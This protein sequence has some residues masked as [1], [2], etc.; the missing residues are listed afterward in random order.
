VGAT[1]IA[2][3]ALEAE[4]LAKLALLSGPDGGRRVLALHGGVLVHDDGDV[5]VI[6]RPK[7]RVAA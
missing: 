2:G 6:E 1:A 3:S 5:E 4:T 7:L